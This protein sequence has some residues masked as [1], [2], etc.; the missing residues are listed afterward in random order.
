VRR[1]GQ[2]LSGCLGATVDSLDPTF[3][4]VTVHGTVRNTCAEE[5]TYARLGALR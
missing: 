3:S 5:V 1:R 4:Y 2:N